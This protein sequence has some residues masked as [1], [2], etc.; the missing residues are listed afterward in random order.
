MFSSRESI[1]GTYLWLSIKYEVKS[2]RNYLRC[3]EKRWGHSP[4]L[5]IRR[6]RSEVLKR[7]PQPA[8]PQPVGPRLFL[9]AFWTHPAS[10]HVDLSNPCFDVARLDTCSWDSWSQSWSDSCAERG[11]HFGWGLGWM[12]VGCTGSKQKA[13]LS[14]LSLDISSYTAL[15]ASGLLSRKSQP[16]WIRSV[17]WVRAIQ[18][19]LSVPQ[20]QTA[21]GSSTNTNFLP[22]SMFKDRF[23]LDKSC[24]WN[25]TGAHMNSGTILGISALL[26]SWLVELN[27]WP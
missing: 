3:G 12:L 16:L 17:L 25:I 26:W 15:C 4:S 23:L 20:R 11:R 27:T 10:H 22:V 1:I 18:A 21:H 24:Y 19:Q 9:G 5:Q 14:L 6:I 13:L 7:K 8:H 2:C